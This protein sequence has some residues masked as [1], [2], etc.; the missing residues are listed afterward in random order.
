MQNIKTQGGMHGFWF[1][2]AV[3]RTNVLWKWFQSRCTKWLRMNVTAA[4]VHTSNHQDVLSTHAC[5]FCLSIDYLVK[6]KCRGFD[7][8]NEKWAKKA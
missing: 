7:N 5:G 1:I 2:I 3:Q 4:S 6:R 8:E